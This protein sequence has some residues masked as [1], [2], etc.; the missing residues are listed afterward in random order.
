MLCYTP[1]CRVY[2][3]L[4]PH[5]LSQFSFYLLSIS[6]S[7]SLLVQMTRA[8]LQV[9]LTVTL[10]DNIFGHTVGIDFGTILEIELGSSPAEIVQIPLVDNLAQAQ[11]NCVYKSERR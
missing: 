8:S 7:S 4:Y 2:N 11:M 5:D 9:D 1:S 3:L 10:E 6:T